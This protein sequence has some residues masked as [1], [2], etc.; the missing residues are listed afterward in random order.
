ML[1][2]LQ[3]LRAGGSTR[4][5]AALRHAAAGFA[6]DAGQRR[7][8]IVLSDG[9]P[10]DIDVHDPRYLSDD[11]RHAVLAAARGGVRLC[12][13]ALAPERCSEVQ[14]IF[15]RDGVQVV[16]NLADVPRAVARLFG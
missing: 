3:E 15:G 13:L 6:G 9:E 16:R 5:G 14:R 10:H 7:C 2:R 4:L 12:C 11:A 8:V 1:T